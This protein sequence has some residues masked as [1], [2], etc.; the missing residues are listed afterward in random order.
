MPDASVDQSAA[1]P[2]PASPSPAAISTAADGL[3]AFI[4]RLKPLSDM[5][6]A[7]KALGSIGNA[8]IE[9]QQAY[10]AAVAQHEDAKSALA[11]TQ[12]NLEALQQQ[13]ADETAAHQAKID[14]TGADALDQANTLI[15]SAKQ[16]ASD[17]LN[18]A[19]TETNRIKA[20]HEAAMVT[21]RQELADVQRSITSEVDALTDV[22][23]QHDE[24]VAQIAAVKQAAA[25]IAGPTP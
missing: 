5:A 18:A 8:T 1:S 22:R 10:A 9:S 12:A 16:Q 3:I 23:S 19:V 15:A 21:A 4:E 14:A 17:M 24:L 2:V 11:G 20:A 7:L 25:S 13:I 6:G